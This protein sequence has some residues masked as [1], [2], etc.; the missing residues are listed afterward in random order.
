VA[1]DGR[2]IGK[3]PEKPDAYESV[4]TVLISHALIWVP[5]VLLIWFAYV[6]GSW[7][8]GTWAGVASVVS[9]IATVGVV[10]FYRRFV[11][12]RRRS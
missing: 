9:S 1:I 6:S 7:I 8:G 5:V 3:E 10:W 11:K 12:R 2:T 4:W